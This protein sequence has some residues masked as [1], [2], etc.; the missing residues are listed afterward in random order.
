MDKI[1]L[2]ATKREVTGKQVNALRRQG[3]LPAIIYGRH[4][5]PL[6]ILL[7]FHDVSRIL[8]GITS[9]Q[10]ITVD[11]DGS[12]HTVLVREKQRDPVR[13]KLIHVDFLAIS[14]TEKLRANVLI[15]VEGE[16]PAVKNFG[17]VVVPV[18]EEVEVECLPKDLPEKIIVDLSRLEK[19]GDAIHV[20]DLTLPQGVEVLTDHDEMVVL[21]KSPE[22]EKVEAVAAEGAEP[23]VVEKGKKE[24]E[25]F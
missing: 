18:L 14:M 13:G 10:L 6:P 9:S 7:D 1:N 21:V 11:V 22:E 19:I 16:A 24:E 25:E 12:K 20:K 4:L 5:S 2:K 8:P 23:E 17:G 3:K 15:E